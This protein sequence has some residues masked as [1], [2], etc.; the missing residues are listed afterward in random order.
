[1]VSAEAEKLMRINQRV[2]SNRRCLIHLRVKV[3][4]LWI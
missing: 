2:V 1:M 3:T 4:I